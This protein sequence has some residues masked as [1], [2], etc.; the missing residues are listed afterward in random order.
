MNARVALR[1]AHG[2]SQG[3]VAD[4]WNER[5]PDD[6]KTFKNISYWEKWPASTG[7]TP[8]LEVLTKLAELY[9]CHVTELLVDAADH[10]HED[11]VFR[12]RSDMAVLP[13]MAHHER[14]LRRR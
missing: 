7:Y 9:S 13:A 14:R 12:A 8:S 1:L 4:Q 10:R 5:W 2:W 3:D 6:I 11:P